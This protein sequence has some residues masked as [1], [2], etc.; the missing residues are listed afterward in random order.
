MPLSII[1]GDLT[2]VRADALVN[3][4]NTW[5]SEGGGV[6]G[7]LFQKAGREQ[8]RAACQ[9]IGRCE[10]GQAV[11]TPAFDLPARYVIHAVGPMYQDG[12]QGEE[13]QL[14]SAYRSALSLAGKH[15]LRSVAFPLISSG[16]YGYPKQEALAVAVRGIRAFLDAQEDELD[17]TL[18]LFHQADAQLDPALRRRL[19]E[20]IEGAQLEEARRLHRMAETRRN[21]R[22]LRSL[23]AE[24]TLDSRGFE[25]EA[26]DVMPAMLPDPGSGLDALIGRMDEGFS[27]SLLKLIDKK[28]LTDAQVYKKANLDRKH[29]SKIRSNPHYAPGKLTVLALIIALELRRD[30]AEDLL[31][32]AGF[33]LSPSH[34]TDII[35]GHFIDQRVYDIDTIN[36]ALFAFDQALLGAKV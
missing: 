11:I 34:K 5:L 8:M 35:V 27:T 4:A 24:E 6:C 7:A 12:R 2:Q 14:E 22:Y 23:A 30:E 36:T 3:A 19:S 18:V 20:L 13:A 15:G 21:A 9:Q 32:R 29:F 16:I 1:T 17:V 26:P 28:G 10:V 31:S 33:A 25:L